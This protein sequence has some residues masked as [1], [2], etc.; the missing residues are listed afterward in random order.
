MI[1]AVNKRSIDPCPQVCEER[2][3]LLGAYQDA[4]AA[5]SASVMDFVPTYGS[6]L[7]AAIPDGVD[8]YSIACIIFAST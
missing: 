6:A 4:A 1:A 2:R 5:Y 7:G 3:R 8:I